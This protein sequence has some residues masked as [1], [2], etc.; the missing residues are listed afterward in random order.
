MKRWSRRQLIGMIAAGAGAAVGGAAVA[1][2]Q[3]VQPAS[4]AAARMPRIGYLGTGS[5][6]ASAPSLMRI[7]PNAFSDGLRALGYVEDNTVSIEWRLSGDQ[8]GASLTTMAAELVELPVDVI[9]TSSTPAVVAAAQATRTIPIVSGGPNRDLRDLG[10]VQSDARPGGNVTGTGANLETYAKL[11]DLLKAAVPSLV[12]VGYLRNPTTPGTQTQMARARDAA[13]A[14]GL[15]F[16][17]LAASA[18]ADIE[19]AFDEALSD[20]VDGVVVSAD[21]A[22]G[23]APGLPITNI[24]LRYRLPTI[25]SQV[26]VYLDEGG[27]MA[28]SPDFAAAQ[29]RAAV[30][31]D[32]ILRG[33]RPAELP[34][35]QAASFEFGINLATARALGLSIPEHVLVQATRVIQ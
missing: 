31:V 19:R 13:A 34:V 11:I 22:F 6:N 30:Y 4:R 21:N 10:L 27:L 16:V 33:A 23:G 35:E 20:H 3:F 7:W 9:V 14:L 12:R 17:E 29:R 32:R 2:W 15:E 5:R 8:P 28:Y 26:E 1:Q 25:Y 18:P 24:P